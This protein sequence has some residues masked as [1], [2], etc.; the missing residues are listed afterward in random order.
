[1]RA[2]CLRRAP[3]RRNGLA[4]R[5]LAHPAVGNTAL[6]VSWHAKPG[7]A[8]GLVASAGLHHSLSLAP[9]AAFELSPELDS[10][11]KRFGQ[12]RSQVY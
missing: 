7:A 1:M 12:E 9:L 8:V 3:S 2:Q 10:A 11:P 6:N 5:P 4:R